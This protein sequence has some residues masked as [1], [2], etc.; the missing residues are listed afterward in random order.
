[1][2]T[3]LEEILA[4]TRDFEKPVALKP[5]KRPLQEMHVYDIHAVTPLVIDSLDTEDHYDIWI[6][7][8]LLTDLSP[9]MTLSVLRKAKN[10]LMREVNEIQEEIDRI[11]LLDMTVDDPRYGNVNWPVYYELAVKPERKRA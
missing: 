10:Q 8:Q 5:A 7:K 9:I 6:D 1:M 3:R 2:V 4:R 11:E